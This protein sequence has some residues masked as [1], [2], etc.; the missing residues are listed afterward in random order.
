[1][2]I[3]KVGIILHSACISWRGKGFLFPGVS[4]AGKSTIAEIW[5]K[6]GEAEV[7]TDERVIIREYHNNLWA[8]GTPWHGTTDV[9]K[10]VGVPVEGILFIQH[11][12]ENR[13]ARIPVIDAANRL[14][15]RCFPA[16]W[17][18]EGLQFALDFCART[19]GMKDCY[20]FQFVPD[21]S[22][23]EFIK[24]AAESKLS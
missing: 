17:Q 10:N 11:G 23:A 2:S 14:L 8:F 1:L 6:D 21:R 22:A 12:R 16:F 18:K 5:Q 7:L 9:H 20:D 24:K 3:N 15:V 13:I 19:A 4:G